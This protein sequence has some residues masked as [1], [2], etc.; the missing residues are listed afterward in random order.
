LLPLLVVQR[1]RS[2]A[3]QSRKVAREDEKKGRTQ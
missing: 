2:A 1:H 3:Q